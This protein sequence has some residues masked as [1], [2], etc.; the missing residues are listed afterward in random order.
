MNKCK[1]PD[2]HPDQDL[3]GSENTDNGQTRQPIPPD[4]RPQDIG[5]PPCKKL[6]PFARRCFAA[7]PTIYSRPEASPNPLEMPCPYAGSALASARPSFSESQRA[8]CSIRRQSWRSG[9]PAHRAASSGTGCRA[10]YS[11]CPHRVSAAIRPGRN[12]QG[13]L[14]CSTPLQSRAGTFPGSPHIR[15]PPPEPG[16]GSSNRRRGRHGCRS[17]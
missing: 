13:S 16:V 7:R 8:P 12:G 14:L 11:H 1:P 9:A 4:R 17:T 5:Q 3:G 6:M 15:R 2:R 10:G